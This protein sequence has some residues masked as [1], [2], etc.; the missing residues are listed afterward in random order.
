MEPTGG[1]NNSNMCPGCEP[2]EMTEHKC[3]FCEEY[4]SSDSL[5]YSD[6]YGF[7]HKTCLDYEVEEMNRNIIN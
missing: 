3:C 1:Y 7:Y 2:L 6:I 4:D 5:E